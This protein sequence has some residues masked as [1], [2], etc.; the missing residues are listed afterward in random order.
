MQLLP[1][2]AGDRRAVVQEAAMRRRLEKYPA[3]FSAHF[4]LGALMLSR[5]EPDAAIGYLRE[6]LRV[7]PEQPAA[8]NALGAAL[9]TK[10]KFAEAE[11]EFRQAL[12]AQP[13][14][15]NARY[16]LANALAA[17]GKLEAAEEEFRRVV[18]AAPEDKAA[19]ERLAEALKESV[20]AA[21]RAGKLEEAATSYAELVNLVP[22]DAGVRNSYGVVLA[23]R[24]AFAAAEKQFAAAVKSDPSNEV[25]RRNLNLARQRAAERAKE[26]P[27]P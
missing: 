12:R 3:D 8:L 9:E 13:E 2:G 22:G 19:R 15:I 23:R 10:S 18:I 5:K 16:N 17:E 14:Y 4:N 6:A 26:P 25:A 27:G 20:A 7:K 21:E 1:R 24:G 11:E